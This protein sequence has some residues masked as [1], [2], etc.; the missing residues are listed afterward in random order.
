M[1]GDI[2]GETDKISLETT[3]VSKCIKWILILKRRDLL[4]TLLT[5]SRYLQCLEDEAEKSTSAQGERTSRK[6]N[7]YVYLC[8]RT[9]YH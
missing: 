6:S 8:S 2:M 1:V 9:G 4:Q 5:E 3:T 7:G